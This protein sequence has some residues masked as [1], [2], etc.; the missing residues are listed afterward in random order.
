V[1]NSAHDEALQKL[2]AE[3]LLK[4]QA[5][6]EKKGAV[7]NAIRPS[8]SAIRPSLIATR[9]SM[10]AIRPIRPTGRRSRR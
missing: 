5:I 2:S 9:P 6:A 10:S 1:A 4:D 8:R 7:F 3:V